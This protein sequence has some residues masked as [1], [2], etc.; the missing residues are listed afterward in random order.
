[1]SG[2]P[3]HIAA[4]YICADFRYL[5]FGALL[6][7]FL[8]SRDLQRLSHLLSSPSALPLSACDNDPEDR[9]VDVPAQLLV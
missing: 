6:R 5:A 9:F 7:I 2:L 8:H 1:M 4:L 3:E